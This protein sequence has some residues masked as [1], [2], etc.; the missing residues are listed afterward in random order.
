[1]TPTLM[2]APLVIFLAA[3]IIAVGAGAL[4]ALSGEPAGLRPS[5]SVL[6]AVS[7]GLPCAR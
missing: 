6:R 5:R 3:M 1:M 2:I 4:L 7:L